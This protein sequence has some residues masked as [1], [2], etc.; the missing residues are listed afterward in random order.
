MVS[1]SFTEADSSDQSLEPAELRALR[2]QYSQD[3]VAAGAVKKIAAFLQTKTCSAVAVA[4]LASILENVPSCLS[5]LQSLGV[6]PLIAESLMSV[7]HTLSSS[8]LRRHCCRLIALLAKER[9]TRDEIMSSGGLNGVALSVF[10]KDAFTRRASTE[11]IARLVDGEGSGS[12]DAKNDEDPFTVCAAVYELDL[13]QP[14]LRC[15]HDSDRACGR[16][17]A[18]CLRTLTLLQEPCATLS[19]GRSI[20]SLASAVCWA[21]ESLP[22]T[23]EC[24]EHISSG[25]AISCQQLVEGSFFKVAGGLLSSEETAINVKRLLC[26]IIGNLAVAARSQE[27][28]GDLVHS[29]DAPILPSGAKLRA[30]GFDGFLTENMAQKMAKLLSVQGCSDAAAFALSQFTRHPELK[31]SVLST[32]T[33]RT[34]VG[35][36][37]EGSKGTKR[38]LLKLCGRLSSLRR[39]AAEVQKDTGRLIHCPVKT[40][41][42]YPFFSFSSSSPFRYSYS[43]FPMLC[44]LCFSVS[45]FCFPVFPSLSDPLLAFIQVLSNDLCPLLVEFLSGG[46]ADLQRAAA[47]CAARWAEA[48]DAIEKRLAECN[49]LILAMDMV[50]SDDLK[51]KRRG[52]LLLKALSVQDEHKAK[53]RAVDGLRVV[54]SCLEVEDGLIRERALH[55]LQ[56]LCIDAENREVL[57]EMGFLRFVVSLLQSENMNV[58]TSAAEL[59]AV[60]SSDSSIRLT[61]NKMGAVESLVD[62]L[63]GESN[64]GRRFV[65]ACLTNL[66]MRTAT[67]VW[68]KEHEKKGEKAFLCRTVNLDVFGLC[69]QS[70]LFLFALTVQF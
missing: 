61:L 46:D 57:S 28:L 8:P 4:A 52:I 13:L 56:R 44:Q 20:Y 62:V 16:A 49:A 14:V 6:I 10:S 70:F 18:A 41:P 51:S 15:L 42:F 36:L 64:Q 34:I 1:R 27:L 65:L 2:R 58:V 30:L 63:H 9:R 5:E 7:D 50:K 26:L 39:L 69:H 54:L 53:I 12:D 40:C 23:L 3:I 66:S 11:C 67:K 68:E 29:L 21:D 55:T 24:L 33:I 47:S 25:D 38:H 35:R 32:V 45:S 19:E 31:Q 48:D 22:L 59:L 37:R 17:A 60:L 43:F